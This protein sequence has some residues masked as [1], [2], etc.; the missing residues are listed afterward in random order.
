M[1]GFIFNQYTPFWMHLISFSTNTL[2]GLW[3]CMIFGLNFIQ[4]NL[5][6]I[7]VGILKHKH[8]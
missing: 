7:H 3:M 8:D 1:N 2:K 6:L 5:L 4:H